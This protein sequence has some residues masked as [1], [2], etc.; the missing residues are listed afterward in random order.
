MAHCN[1]QSRTPR[2]SHH[3]QDDRLFFLSGGIP[4]EHFD[5]LNF[6]STRRGRRLAVS[7]PTGDPWGYYTERRESHHMETDRTVPETS[8]QPHT[9]SS[10]EAMD[11]DEGQRT[12]ARLLEEAHRL[13]TV[14]REPPYASIDETLSATLQGS[15]AAISH[16]LATLDLRKLHKSETDEKSPTPVEMKASL[17]TGSFSPF[18]FEKEFHMRHGMNPEDADKPWREHYQPQGMIMRTRIPDEGR[19]SVGT[20]VSRAASLTED[21]ETLRTPGVVR[22]LDVTERGMY[23][24]NILVF[25]ARLLQDIISGRW[26]RQQMYGSTPGWYQ[27]SFYDITSP[28]AGQYEE[29]QAPFGNS[30]LLPAYTT[31]PRLLSL[32]PP[33]DVASTVGP[34]STVGPSAS[35]NGAT[36]STKKVDFSIIHDIE[37]MSSTS[38]QSD[39]PRKN[40]NTTQLEDKPIDLEGRT[41]EC[42]SQQKETFHTDE[43]RQIPNAT[44]LEVRDMDITTSDH[45]VYYRIYPDFQLPLPN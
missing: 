41:S 34:P 33:S 7:A 38:S 23:A 5:D 3:L 2:T 42:A 13:S 6:V 28:W 12:T 29:S 15:E 43:R 35:E 11:T 45:D 17:P 27:D 18:D 32:G 31:Q 9:E 20:E 30:R 4:P 1:N 40:I 39:V 22:D 16:I 8:T 14:A 21:I 37:E 25:D 19:R 44:S 36:T 26:S 24:E 10:M